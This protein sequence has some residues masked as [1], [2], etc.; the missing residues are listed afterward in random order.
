VRL[1][2]VV[3]EIGAER[4]R[5]GERPLVAHPHVRGT[6][7]RDAGRVGPRTGVAEHRRDLLIVLE[8]DVGAVG[9]LVPDLGGGGQCG[10]QRHDGEQ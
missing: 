1:A 10:E 7:R 4:E 8:I 5:S 3:V 6:L 9:R 2:K